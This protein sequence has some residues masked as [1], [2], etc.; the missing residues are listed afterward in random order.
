MKITVKAPR[1]ASHPGQHGH[2][3]CDIVL[4]LLQLKKVEQRGLWVR[5]RKRRSVLRSA[6]ADGNGM[7]RPPGHLITGAGR[8]EVMRKGGGKEVRSVR[9]MCDVCAA[10]GDRAAVSVDI[11]AQGS[12][13]R[14]DEWHRINDCAIVITVCGL[15]FGDFSAGSYL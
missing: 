6:R 10:H 11:D 14:E 7:R 4:F 1:S 9:C 5:E 3:G 2:E 12:S 8:E 15:M 13:L